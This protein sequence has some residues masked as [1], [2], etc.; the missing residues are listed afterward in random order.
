MRTGS[1]TGPTI[2]RNVLPRAARL[3]LCG[4]SWPVDTGADDSA[5]SAAVPGMTVSSA[6]PGTVRIVDGSDVSPSPL[7]I[8]PASGLRQAADAAKRA[9][10]RADALLA[11]AQA[12][13][14]RDRP[15]RHWAD[16]GETNLR[17][18]RVRGE[19]KVV[20]ALEPSRGTA[21]EPARRARQHRPLQPR[22]AAAPCAPDRKDDDFVVEASVIHVMFRPRH[23]DPAHRRLEPCC[24]VQR[25]DVGVLLQSVEHVQELSRKQ[26]GGV[27]TIG[28]PPPLDS[29]RF[30]TRARRNSD[31]H[32]RERSSAAHS[33]ASIVRPAFA[34]SIPSRIAS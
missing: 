5:E 1:G 20:Q 4:H 14:R 8:S 26:V 17:N 16:G 24:L 25:P 12:Y 2:P 13:L 19:T 22:T 23:Q 6:A 15:I 29:I 7:P 31:L 9:F 34:S 21:R 18:P 10:N 33:P 28:A 30:A 11:I 27:E 32:S 3:L